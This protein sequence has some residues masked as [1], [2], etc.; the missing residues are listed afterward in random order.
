MRIDLPAAASTTL[1]NVKR[2][3]FDCG[4]RWRRQTD[5][6]LHWLAMIG[7]LQVGAIDAVKLPNHSQKVC[8]PTKQVPHNDSC[9]LAHCRPAK[10]FAREDAL[11]FDELLVEFRERQLCRQHCMLN[12]EKAVIARGE[13]ARFGAP[14]LVPG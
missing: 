10:M 14:R 1:V 13:T 5:L 9:A 12:I 3:S 6:V 2:V 8:L 11:S 4:S 7:E